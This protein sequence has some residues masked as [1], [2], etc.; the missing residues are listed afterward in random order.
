M[1]PLAEEASKISEPLCK[2]SKIKNVSGTVELK[3][4]PAIRKLTRELVKLLI[5][6]KPLEE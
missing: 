1:I 2:L 5:V 6:T 3:M 4:D